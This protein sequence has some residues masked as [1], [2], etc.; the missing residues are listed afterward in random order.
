MVE[1]WSILTAVH[2]RGERLEKE[3]FVFVDGT[4][5]PPWERSVFLGYRRFP[6]FPLFS[7]MSILLLKFLF[8]LL[9][10]NLELSVLEGAIKMCSGL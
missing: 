10:V 2:R 9:A 8:L 1:R 5:I 4:P 3:V 6:F 7:K